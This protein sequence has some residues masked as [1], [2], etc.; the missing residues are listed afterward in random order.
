MSEDIQI[1][2]TEKQ[3]QKHPLLDQVKQFLGQYYHP[4]FSLDDA[5]M[6]LSTQEI[7]HQIQKLYPSFEYSQET[8]AQWMQELGFIFLDFGEMK[9]EWL[10]KKA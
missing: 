7:Y 8:I 4:A 10:I 2:P 6:H 1:P 3:E 5:D 9:L